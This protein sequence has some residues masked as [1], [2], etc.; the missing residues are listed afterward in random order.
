MSLDDSVAVKPS[1]TPNT[2]VFDSQHPL[3]RRAARRQA[4][5]RLI[6]FPHAG[7]TIDAFSQWPALLPDDVELVAV[8]L[9]GRGDRLHEPAPAHAGS[10][11]GSL[12]DALSAD[13]AVPFA[14][15]GHSAGAW[16]AF[17]VARALSRTGI[18]PTRL[19]LSG[20]PAPHLPRRDPLHHLDD[21]EFDRRICELGG[22]PSALMAH[23]AARR[24]LLA[25]VR[26]D[27]QLWETHVF[28][29]GP[30]ISCAITAFGGHVDP[31]A[32]AAELQ[33]WE[34][35]T[36][37]PFRFRLLTGGHFFVDSQRSTL[38]SEI[39]SDLNRVLQ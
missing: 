38:V 12:V 15:F 16:C 29:D 17:E 7:A 8:Q 5:R 34:A 27:F 31:R 33:A 25:P 11:I 9:A 26:A 39:V 37:G 20:Q 22:I 6:C 10:L 14:L 13:S 28:Q 35:Q 4:T 23:A 19:F 30:P 3:L 21:V 1:A 24:L 32:T 36:S 2:A 18:L